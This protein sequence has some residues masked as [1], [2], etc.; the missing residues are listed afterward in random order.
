MEEGIAQ[1]SPR[2]AASRTNAV[3]QSKA[4]ERQGQRHEVKPR[5]TDNVPVEEPV[6]GKTIRKK[7][8]RSPTAPVPISYSSISNFS[9]QNQG[10]GETSNINLGNIQNMRNRWE[11]GSWA[12]YIAQSKNMKRLIQA[13][14]DEESNPNVFVPRVQRS[15][16]DQYP[17][18][19]I[20][21]FNFINQGTGTMN[22]ENVA[23][24]QYST[25]QNV[26]Q[27]VLVDSWT[28]IQ[29]VTCD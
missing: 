2:K 10:P 14:E 1:Q 27:E 6:L 15:Q 8:Q 11:P 16:T 18:S 22:N 29:G 23:N 21:D 19:S 7:K 25:I 3:V 13:H 28:T 5:I 9:F 20:S 4:G 17:I 26:W 12:N 24:I